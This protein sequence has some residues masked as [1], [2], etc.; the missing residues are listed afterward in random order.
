[1]RLGEMR[2]GPVDRLDYDIRFGEWLTDDD[3]IVEAEAE[4]EDGLTVDSVA[5]NNDDQIV[6]VWLSG[7]EDGA[8]YE[9][10]VTITTT[11]GRVKHVCF[12]VRVNEC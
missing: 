8:T 11:E 4:A 7:G 1:M 5:V 2:K 6:K 3:T 10:G 9:V 12:R